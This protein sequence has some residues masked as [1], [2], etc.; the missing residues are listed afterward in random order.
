MKKKSKI[1][2]HKLSDVVETFEYLID[3][4]GISEPTIAYKTRVD[5]I[6]SDLFN[7]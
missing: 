1:K 2:K 3:D 5:R 7:K 6:T 4:G